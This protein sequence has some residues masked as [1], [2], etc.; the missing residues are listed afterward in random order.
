MKKKLVLLIIFLVFYTLFLFPDGTG[1]SFPG[2][3]RHG[4]IFT[5]SEIFLTSLRNTLGE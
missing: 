1:C 4:T 5:V 2:G 3:V